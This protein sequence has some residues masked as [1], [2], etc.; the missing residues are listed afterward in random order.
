MSFDANPLWL[1]LVLFA[2]ASAVVWLAGNRLTKYA[3]AVSART[4]LGHA[5]L[6]ALLL[7]GI[8]SLPE[9]ATTSTAALSGNPELAVNNILGGIAMQLAVLAFADA[10]IGERGLSTAAGASVLL[11]QGNGLMLALALAG[12][13]IVSG[14]IVVLGIDLWTVA[15][16]VVVILIFSAIRSYE[17]QPRWRPVRESE[18][19]PAEVRSGEDRA[20]QTFPGIS[21]A[22][23]AVS[24]VTAGVLVVA[25]GYLVTRAAEVISVQTDLGAS[26][27]GA[28]FLAAA[29]SLPE[30]STTTGA[31]RLGL[32][33]LA[34]SNIFGTNLFDVGLLFVADALYRDGAALDAVDDFALFGVLLGILLTGVFVAGI[35][36]GRKRVILRM[37]V[38]SAVVLLAYAVGVLVLF[39]LR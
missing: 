12:A 1:N 9:L 20:E 33:A 39:G 11:L 38:D 31:V 21:N 25:G 16:L 28:I 30:L 23:L 6:G 17:E 18:E 15:L 8:T 36:Q 14:S 37:G 27:T 24:T 10:M 22:R 34:F 19:T 2:V 13:G 35:L 7:G 5:L 32:H 26:F 3:D 29:T 4:R